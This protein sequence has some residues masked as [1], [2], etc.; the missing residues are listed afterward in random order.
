MA[1]GSRPL[2]CR[3]AHRDKQG[4]YDGDSEDEDDERVAPPTV[5]LRPVGD[6]S[7]T[8][9][10]TAD[11]HRC[12]D[13]QYI[14]VGGSRYSLAEWFESAHSPPHVDLVLFAGDLGLDLNEQLCPSGRYKDRRAGYGEAGPSHPLSVTP[15]AND[16]RTLL[17]FNALL[18]RICKAK[19]MAHVVICGGNHDGLICSDDVCL[20]CHRKQAGRC[21]WGGCVDGCGWDGYGWAQ[22]PVSWHAAAARSVLLDGI[23]QSRARVLHDSKWDIM[24][25]SGVLVRV[26]GS[27]WTCYDSKNKQHITGSH[28]WRP[29]GGTIYGGDKLP[30][31]GGPSSRRQNLTRPLPTLSRSTL[32]Q[33]S[34]LLLLAAAA[35]SPQIATAAAFSPRRSASLPSTSTVMSSAQPCHESI[36]GSQP[37]SHSIGE[38]PP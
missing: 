10:A 11:L 18:R 37:S 27:P 33:S 6:R 2:A 22:K 4:N 13:D 7:I 24:T 8:V 9:V 25:E 34:L 38:P 3:R 17:S 5:E 1:S 36:A 23:D 31:T 32:A 26:V 20:A 35:P 30:L 14:H 19:P 28:H 21:E 16:K 12:H 15:R 29:R